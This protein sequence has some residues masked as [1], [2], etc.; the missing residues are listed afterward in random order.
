MV[1]SFFSKGKFPVISVFFGFFLTFSPYIHIYTSNARLCNSLNAPLKTVSFHQK[2]WNWDR[3]IEKWPVFCSSKNT[4][5]FASTT[6]FRPNFWW[7]LSKDTLFSFFSKCRFYD[8][9]HRIFTITRPKSDIK[10]NI[11]FVWKSVKNC[12]CYRASFL[13]IYAL[14]MGKNKISLRKNHFFPCFLLAFTFLVYRTTLLKKGS[15]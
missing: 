12:R 1:Y 8:V 14:F 5:F 13:I 7:S 2:L 3:S 10:S 6:Y 15:R 11:F 9:S 4:I